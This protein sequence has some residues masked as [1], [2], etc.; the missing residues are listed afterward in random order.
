[1]FHSDPCCGVKFPQIKASKLCFHCCVLYIRALWRETTSARFCSHE[2]SQS[3]DDWRASL[4]PS[5]QRGGAVLLY[6]LFQ[7]F[8]CL[9]LWQAGLH[10]QPGAR[11]FILDAL[12]T[13]TIG[14]DFILFI[15]QPLV[16][17]S[18]YV[19]KQLHSGTEV[20]NSFSSFLRLLLSPLLLSSF[21]LVWLLP[22]FSSM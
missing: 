9:H 2:L 17:C 1:M 11:G 15:I 14:N 5:I 7:S 12:E 20:D 21:I 8:C 13:G 10:K 22:S 4:A 16:S 18:I 3:K 19:W 6:L